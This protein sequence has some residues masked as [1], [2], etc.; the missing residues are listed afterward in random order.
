MSYQKG[1]IKRDP[2]AG[3][4]AIRTVF[5]DTED[6]AHMQWLTAT[7]GRGAHNKT[8]ADV[9]GWDDLYVPEPVVEPEMFEEVEPPVGEEEQPV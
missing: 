7:T 8:N 3:T 2:V 4:V 6:F 1:H 5:P 9:E